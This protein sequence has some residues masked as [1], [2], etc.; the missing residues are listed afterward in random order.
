[1][2]NIVKFFRE[3]SFNFRKNRAIKKADCLAQER[4]QKYL[5]LYWRKQFIVMSMQ[6]IKTLIRTKQ[7]R[8]SPEYYRDHAVYTAMP[9]PR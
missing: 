8:Y 5:V 7:M 2:M 3:W 6:R 4:R 1:M 9:K